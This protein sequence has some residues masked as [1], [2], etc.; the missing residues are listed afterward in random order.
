MKCIKIVWNYL[1][2]LLLIFQRLPLE[3]VLVKLFMEYV[4]MFKIPYQ[5][6]TEEDAIPEDSAYCLSK[7][8]N[9]GGIEDRWEGTLF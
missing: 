1:Y 7:M 9:I 4:K 8:Q 5:S 2:L 6:R 3:G